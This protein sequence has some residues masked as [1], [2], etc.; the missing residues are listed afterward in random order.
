MIYEGVRQT[1][2]KEMKISHSF[3][4]MV[5]ALCYAMPLADKAHASA[6]DLGD[7]QRP[8]I[9][10]PQYQSTPKYSL[11]VLGSSGDVKVWMVEDGRRLFVDKNANGDLTDDGPPIEPG[12]VRKLDAQRF[13]FGYLLDAITP[14]DGSRHTQFSLRRWNYGEKDDAYGLSLSVNA[15]L[16]L[17]AGWF[18]TFWSTKRETAPVIHFGGRFT[19]KLLRAKEF[20]IGSGQQSLSLGLM[21]PGSG[22]GAES[23]LSI[24]ALPGYLVPVLDIEWPAPGGSPPLRTSH[25]LTERCCYWEFYSKVFEVPNGAIVGRAKVSVVFPA[26]ATSIVLAT[27]EFEVPVVAQ[28]HESEPPRK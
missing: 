10:E 14:A 5:T 18:G 22:P 19:P 12:T 17:Y 25:R 6:N 9:K 16:P 24:D 8:P 3:F 20:K 28:S 27:T 1:P 2:L 23:R 26:S 15:Q 11:I 21:N 13:D 4:A 7:I